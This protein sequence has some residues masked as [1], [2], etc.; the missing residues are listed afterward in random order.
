L[1]HG[2]CWIPVRVVHSLIDIHYRVTPGK[3]C[4]V[5]LGGGGD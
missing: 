3:P 4:V 2:K 1:S 5:I